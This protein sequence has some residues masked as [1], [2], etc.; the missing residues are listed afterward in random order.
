MGRSHVL[1]AGPETVHW[2]YFDAAL[3]PVL[4]VEPGDSVRIESVN[5]QPRD[6]VGLPFDMLPEHRRIHEACAPKLGPHI[7]TGPVAINGAEPGDLLEVRVR[8]IELRQDWGWNAMRPLRGTLPDDFPRTRL[9]HVPI[10]RVQ[11]TAT[12][13]FG[14]TLPLRPF[15]GVMGV[16]PPPAYGAISSIEPREHGGNIDNKELGAGATLFLPVHASGALF[17]AGDGH[18]VQGDGEVILTALETSL[19]GLFEF[20]LHKAVHAPMPLG[21]SPTHLITMGF[22]EDLDTAA[23]QAL[24][25]MIALLGDMTGWAREDAYVFCSMACDLHVTQMVNGEKGV[26]AMVDR[27]LLSSR[28]DGSHPLAVALRRPA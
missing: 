25:G 8:E 3:A 23:R 13:P 5:G 21:L 18:A 15:F 22:D 17:S 4:T 10:D 14:I 20:H 2:G 16:A 12:L 26:H 6:L 7:V 19:A 28:L 11:R 24:R 27:A 9:L 1:H